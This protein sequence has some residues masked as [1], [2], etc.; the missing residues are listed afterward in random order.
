MTLYEC[1]SAVL[2][3]FF[4]MIKWVFNDFLLRVKVLNVPVLYLFFAILII[5]IIISG[6][7][8]TTQGGYMNA[9]STSRER[10]REKERAARREEYAKRRN[11]NK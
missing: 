11:S 9:V 10:K 5:G 7:L 6:V 3:F 2:D 8:N 1:Q 4:N